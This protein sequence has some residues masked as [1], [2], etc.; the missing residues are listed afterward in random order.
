MIVAHQRGL[1]AIASRLAKLGLDDS[2][3]P[4]SSSQ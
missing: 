1:G 3:A 2:E 4:V